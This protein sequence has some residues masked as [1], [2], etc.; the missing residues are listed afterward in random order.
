M[1]PSLEINCSLKKGA[2]ETSEKT[3]PLKSGIADIMLTIA[4]IEKIFSF[5]SFFRVLL[6]Y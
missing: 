4:R 1:R 3:T 6:Q 5:I 2:R